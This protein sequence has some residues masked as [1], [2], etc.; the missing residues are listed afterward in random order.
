[1]K[2]AFTDISKSGNRYEIDDDTWFPEPALHRIAPVRAELSLQRKGDSRV[3]VSGF[4]R[5]GVRLACDRCLGQY[6]FPVDVN[7]HLVLEVSSD[8]DWRM[9]E[10]ECTGTDLDIVL[11]AEPVADLADILRQQLFLSLPDK[12]ICS[13]QCRGLCPQCGQDLNDGDC[14]CMPAEQESPFAVL[15]KLKNK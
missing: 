14:A 8:D 11:Q 7:F 1:M 13:P 2:V 3:E 5:T 4:L 6:D 10:L 12:L 9:K 15:A